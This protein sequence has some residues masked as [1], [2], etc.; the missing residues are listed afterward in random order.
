MVLPRGSGSAVRVNSAAVPSVTPLPA[1]ML[2]TPPFGVPVTEAEAV[3]S[4]LELVAIT[5][6]VYSVPASRFGIV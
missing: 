2:T 6:T 4:A 5:C 3:P 1:V